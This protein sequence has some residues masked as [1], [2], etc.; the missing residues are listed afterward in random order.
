MAGRVALEIN[1]EG[2]KELLGLLIA[3]SEG[4]NPGQEILILMFV[5]WVLGVYL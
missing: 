1:L 4:A 2:E 3:D 5:L